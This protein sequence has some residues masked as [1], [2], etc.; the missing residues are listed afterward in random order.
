MKAFCKFISFLAVV[1]IAVAV[2]FFIKIEKKSERLEEYM[3]KAQAAYSEAAGS[4]NAE[5]LEAIKNWIVYKENW[6]KT[7]KAQAYFF[8]KELEKTYLP[9]L[10]Y[11]GRAAFAVLCAVVLLF[12]LLLLMLAKNP[13]PVKKSKPE[14]NKPE[15]NKPATNSW[16]V[17]KEQ[18]PVMR[19]TA[20]QPKP[21]PADA[22]T[23]LRKAAECAESEP[24]QSVGYLEQAME[25]SLSTK[26]AAPALLLCGSLRLKNK[27]GEEQGRKQL[28]KIIDLYPQSVEAKKAKVVLNTFK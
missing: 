18:S 22:Q 9:D 13:P 3:L 20:S 2:Y 25:E 21:K 4:G 19:P 15:K 12:A 8:V 17:H 24:T 23:L 7:P 16:V 14:K 10:N 1:L 6:E 5:Y 27:M 11:N 28:D 26:L